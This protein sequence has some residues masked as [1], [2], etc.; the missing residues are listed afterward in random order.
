MANQDVRLSAE[1]ETELMAAFREWFELWTAAGQSY[2]A[3]RAALD[4]QAAEI[5]RAEANHAD[6]A[7][8]AAWIMIQN[9][10]SAWWELPEQMREWLRVVAPIDGGFQAHAVRVVAAAVDDD[11][12]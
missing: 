7:R 5:F 8:R 4:A 11:D 2:D 9:T 12:E 1:Q 10:L 3:E 6:P